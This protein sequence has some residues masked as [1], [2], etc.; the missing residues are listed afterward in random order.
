MGGI[1]EEVTED[2]LV[3]VANEVDFVYRGDFGDGGQAVVDDG[4]AGDI[5]EGLLW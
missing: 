2:G 3:I 1:L 5:E 4:V